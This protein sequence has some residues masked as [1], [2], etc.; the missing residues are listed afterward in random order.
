MRKS[1]AWILLLVWPAS[2]FAYDV[3][4]P[5]VLYATGK[6]TVN[7]NLVNGSSTIPPG[8]VVET[9]PDALA[10]LTISGSTV[11]IQPAS[12]A[13]FD[14]NELYLDHGGV[15]VGSSTLLRV[16]VKCITATPS[17]NTWTQYDVVNVSGTVQIVDRKG[18]VDI[19]TGPAYDLLKGAAASP[20]ASPQSKST[21]SLKEGQ[22]YNRYET[23]GCPSS[24]KKGAPPAA[25]TGILNSPYARYIGAGVIAGVTIW[26]LLQST[27]RPI[28]PQD[29]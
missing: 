24:A 8:S 27:P 9:S 29:P 17:A 15:T 6:V 1:L 3:T 4:T 21:D 25:V 5:A 2:S 10:N 12:L 20:S 16:H 18:G 23:D 7:G 26:V 19:T 11:V 28:S 22:Q 14:G 13:R